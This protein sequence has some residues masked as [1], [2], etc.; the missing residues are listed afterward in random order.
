MTRTPFLAASLFYLRILLGLLAVAGAASLAGMQAGWIVSADSVRAQPPEDD[1]GEEDIAG[2]L[3]ATGPATIWSQLIPVDTSLVY[4]LSAEFR[5]FALEGDPLDP[6][7]IYLGVATY[8]KNLNELRSRPGT[9]RYGGAF[10]YHL[11]QV[12]EWVTLAGSM[13]GE[14]DDNHNQFRPGTRFVRIVALLNYR[15]EATRSEIRNVQ[16]VPRLVMENK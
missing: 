1:G 3:S 11:S 7:R 4:D 8:D 14:G 13:T 6:A 10:N 12:Q 2:D 15:G 5:A 16:F 9:Y